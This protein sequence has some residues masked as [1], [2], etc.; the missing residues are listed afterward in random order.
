MAPLSAPLAWS[1]VVVFPQCGGC[2]PAADIQ[3]SCDGDSLYQ[4]GCSVEEFGFDVVWPR[5]NLQKLWY[6]AD[7]EQDTAVR[8]GHLDIIVHEH[9]LAPLL[10]EA[11][12][13]WRSGEPHVT[14]STR[15]LAVTIQICR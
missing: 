15:A 3:E 14:E 12:D 4:R 9:K 10:A 7:L 2:I 1:S 13:F 8:V 5:P 11:Y 6:V